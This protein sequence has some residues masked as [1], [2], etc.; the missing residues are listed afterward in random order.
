MSHILADVHTAEAAI[1]QATGTDKD[2]LEQLYYQRIMQ[3][4]GVTRAEYDSTLSIIQKDPDLLVEVYKKASM[5][6]DSLG[7]KFDED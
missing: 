2:S 7:R 6:L 1:R 3:I 4:H 5:V